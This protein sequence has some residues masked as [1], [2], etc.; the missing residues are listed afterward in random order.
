M[1]RRKRVLLAA[2]MALA[3]VGCAAAL[4]ALLGEK[5]SGSS[6]SSL[7]ASSSAAVKPGATL[8]NA[9]A[10]TEPKPTSAGAEAP[11]EEKPIEELLL[12]V[13]EDSGAVFYMSRVREALREGNPAFARELLRQ[14][15]E[16]HPNS[17]LVLEAEALFEELR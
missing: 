7:A 10:K 11:R 17:V 16:A 4:V 8:E 14:M 6:A 13:G 15:R 3:L 2:A 1:K 5:P 9:A 12:E